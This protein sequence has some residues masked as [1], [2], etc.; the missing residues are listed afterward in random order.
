MFQLSS[1]AAA[2][3]FNGGA[4]IVEQYINTAIAIDDLPY[5]GLP[6]GEVG[7][8]Q[9]MFY[10]AIHGDVLIEAKIARVDFCTLLGK[11]LHRCQAD[12]ARAASDQSDLVSI[13][14][15]FSSFAAAVPAIPNTATAE[16]ATE[17]SVNLTLSRIQFLL[18]NRLIPAFLMIDSTHRCCVPSS[19]IF[20]VAQCGINKVNRETLLRRAQKGS[21]PGCARSA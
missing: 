4:R 13:R 19:R 11:E 16:N 21:A 15:N 3:L 6:I 8:V 9:S 7:Y 1:S 10:D 20:H 5:D 12:T 18:D 17:I 2:F 14:T